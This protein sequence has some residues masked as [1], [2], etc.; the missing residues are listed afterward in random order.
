MSSETGAVVASA[1]LRADLA[2]GTLDLWPL[3]LLHEGAVTVSVAVDRRV[4]VRAR[5]LEPGSWTEIVS[6]D[7]GCRRRFRAG[8]G[9]VGA[10]PLE[11]VERVVRTV[12]GGVPFGVA[13]RSPVSAG[14]GLGTSSALG[15]AAA[16]AVLAALGRRI[17]RP[18]LVELVRDLE[19]IVLG[20]PTGTQD[21][22]TAVRGG[23]C[24]LEQHPGGPTVRRLSAGRLSGLARRLVLFDAR[25]PRS[26]GPSNWDM[27]RRRIEGKPEAVDALARIRDAGRAAL[28]AVE[29]SDWAALG[30]AMRKDLEARA[31]WSP[32]VLTPRLRGLVKAVL[33]AG[34]LGVK[35][36][37][38]GGGGWGAAL[39]D[40]DRRSLV[41]DAIRAAGGEPGAAAPSGRGLVVSRGSGRR[42]PAAVARERRTRSSSRNRST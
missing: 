27:Y 5:R 6:L 11:L 35:V 16:A 22:V 10:G 1:P 36:C 8:D 25:E 31:G 32:K 20:V 30:R 17:V 37:G 14:S 24:V 23:L 42:S 13:T 41:E 3:G 4:E 28:E 34:A 18:R 15:V 7:L 38:A 26:S 2:G 40:P 12:S 33:D 19:A 9:A 21:H 29:S 39:A